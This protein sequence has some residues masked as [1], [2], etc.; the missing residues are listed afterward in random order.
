M[1]TLTATPPLP[2]ASRPAGFDGALRSEW[3][4]LR[5]VRSTIWSLVAIA[6]IAIGLM[7][8][9]AW[10][11]VHRWERFEPA[12]KANLLQRPVEIIIVRPVFI[13]QLVV[14]VLGV[15]VISAEYTTG[16]IRSTL[17]S[18]PRRMTVLGAKIVVFAALMVV[19]GEV[20]A[21]A[22]FFVG[23]QVIAAHIPVNL[24]DPGVTRSVIGAGLYIA[25]LGLF[26]LAFGA[27]LR[28]TAGAI[29]AVVGLILIVS[30]LTGL[31]PDSWGH[32]IN[33]YMPTNAGQLIMQP[34]QLPDDL[35]SPWQGFAVFGGWT[36][37]LLIIAAV[38]FQRRDA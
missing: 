23:R 20:L 27:I 7:S 12:E 8:L 22:A 11:I 9:I 38:M 31:L 13:A 32:H 1:T 29:T 24:S 34:H 3:T 30:N 6:G 33:A 18:Q 35:L 19:V 17:Q 14:A 28:H 2:P 15:M 10:T 16:M 21:F 37:L 26:S 36:V 5:S 25:L 4:K